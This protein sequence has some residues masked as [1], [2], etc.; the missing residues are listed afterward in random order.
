MLPHDVAKLLVDRIDRALA[1]DAHQAVDFLLYALLSLVELRTVCWNLRPDS[2]VS[3]I[4]LDGVRKNEVTVSKTLHEGRSTETVSTM[5]REVTLADSEETS[6]GG[7]QFIVNPYTTHG[8]VNSR[9]DHH[10]V[11]VLHAIDLVCEFAWIDVGD[12]LIHV[13]EVAITLADNVDTE[14]LDRLR[15]VEEHGKTCVVY[16]EALVATLLGSA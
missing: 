15:E 11:V 5:V 9:E 13:E 1:L 16:A 14:T 8:V 4:V 6:D 3:K 2:L 10:W 7:H 12:L